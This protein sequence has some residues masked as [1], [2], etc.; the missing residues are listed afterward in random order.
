MSPLAVAV[1]RNAPDLVRRLIALGAHCQEPHLSF[2]RK[3]ALRRDCH[4]ALRVLEDHWQKMPM[5]SIHQQQKSDFSA[6]AAKWNMDR[7]VVC[8]VST[9]STKVLNFSDPTCK[10]MPEG[11]SAGFGAGFCLA[12]Q[13]EPV[14]EDLLVLDYQSKFNTEDKIDVPLLIE[15]L[16]FLMQNTTQGE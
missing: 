13:Q 2:L 5:A 4:D 10:E 6:G 1:G 11:M 3:L 7:W 9:E 14:N 16:V 8:W 12:P 15:L